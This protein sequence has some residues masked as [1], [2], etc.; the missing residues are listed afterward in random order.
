MIAFN[1]SAKRNQEMPKG[2]IA[3]KDDGRRES[4]TAG[5]GPTADM[6]GLRFLTVRFCFD[7]FIRFPEFIAK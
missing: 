2:R 6:Q 4:S 5:F 1:A 3:L 7:P